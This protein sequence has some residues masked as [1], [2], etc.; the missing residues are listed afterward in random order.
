MLSF[1]SSLRLS[2]VISMD[3]VEPMGSVTPLLPLTALVSDALNRSPTLCVFVH[4]LVPDISASIEP[5]AIVPVTGAGAAGITGAGVGLGA[6]TLGGGADAFGC[7]A[8][9]VTGTSFN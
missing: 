6:V 2:S 4:T 9:G 5:D 7:D 1:E 3:T 8:G